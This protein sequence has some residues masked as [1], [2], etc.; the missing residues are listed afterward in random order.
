MDIQARL[1]ISYYKEIAVISE[2]HNIYIVQHLH[3]KK[4]FIK[5]ILSVYNRAIYEYLK[6][7]PIAHTPRIYEI[8]EENH[9][10]TIIEEYI[11]GNTL[12]QIL[13]GRTFFSNRQITDIAIQLC[14]LIQKL[15]ACTPPII[16]RDIKPSNIILTPSGELFLL[17]FNA[18]KYFTDTKTADT[19]LLGTKGYAAPEQYGFGVSTV[20]TDIYAI[21]MLLNDL[22][23]CDA[24]VQSGQKNIFSPI[25]S[26]C[27]RLDPNERYK[28]VSAILRILHKH[29]PISAVPLQKPSGWTSFLP[30]GFQKVSPIRMF[31]SGIGYAFLFWLALSLESPNFTPSMLAFERVI[32]LLLFLSIVFFSANYRNVQAHIPL[33]RTQNIFLRILAVLFVDVLIFFAFVFIL[34]LFVSIVS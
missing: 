15:H 28:D 33:C 14:L 22:T 6:A 11:S 16:H 1:A 19:I 27:T 13:A 8:Y 5:K 9:S 30:P 24:Y 23:T 3:S 2:S 7:N 4:I 26:T 21:G 34:V 20:Q 10:L 12:E 32:C 31:L 25:I 17:D 18:A 29:E